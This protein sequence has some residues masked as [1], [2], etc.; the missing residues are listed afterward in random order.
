MNVLDVEETFYRFC[1]ERALFPEGC[2]VVVA[3]SGGADSMLLLTLLAKYQDRFRLRL[4]AMNLNHMLREEAS[5]E[6][7]LVSARCRELLVPC[8]LYARDIAA[9][10]REM[11]CSIE[12]AGRSVRYELLRELKE[13]LS[14]DLIATAHHAD[15]NAETVLMRL[16]RG[17]G[18]AGLSA[19]AAKRADLVRPLLCVDK[20]QIIAAC[21]AMNIPY[22][23]DQS[24]FSREYFRN[25]VRLDIMPL[26][27]RENPKIASSLR[28]LSETAQSLNDFVGTELAKVKII[29]G[30]GSAYVGLSDFRVL[31]PYLQA[32]LLLRLAEAGGAG[33]DI[34]QAQ[35]SSVVKLSEGDG[36]WQY[37]APGGRYFREGE[38]LYFSVL[39]KP[40]AAKAYSYPLSRGAVHIFAA[41]KMVIITKAEQKSEKN[42]SI[43]YKKFVDYDKIRN[44]LFVRSRADGDVFCP[45][46]GKTKKLKKYLNEKRLTIRERDKLPLI[47]DE[48]GIIAVGSLNIDDGRKI[49]S[50]TTK[51]LC[52]HIYFYGGIDHEYA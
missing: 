4:T 33:A 39:K 29:R 2:G 52:I 28:A 41:Q 19:I 5:E 24:N 6:A 26:L 8:V 47:C 11:H 7:E 20:S 43:P 44:R 51:L 27:R 10:A 49:T 30:E 14:Y 36:E 17:T 38:R 21:E 31:H 22:A 23:N 50:E 3:V 15:D 34:G 45:C 46:G 9:A 18:V 25:R 1:T 42:F 40:E 48:A 12:Q 13:Q 32:R 35:L 37:F 16:L